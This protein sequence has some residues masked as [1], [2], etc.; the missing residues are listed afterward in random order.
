[1][2]RQSVSELAFYVQHSEDESYT[3]LRVA[4]RSGDTH[5]WDFEDA[6]HIKLSPEP[7]GWVRVPLGNVGSKGMDRYVRTHQLQV[8]VQTMYQQ[9]RDTHIRCIKVFGPPLDDAGEAAQGSSFE[10]SAP[11][12]S[13]P[14]RPFVTAE[15]FA[16]SSVR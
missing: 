8:V 14:L 11:H 1:M 15:M 5:T 7:N 2:Q 12:P 3:P 13:A 6:R 9:G 10:D 16:G 4:I